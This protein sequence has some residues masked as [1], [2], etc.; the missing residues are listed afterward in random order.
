MRKS[1]LFVI[2]D[3]PFSASY[4][5]EVASC[6]SLQPI[7]EGSPDATQTCVP[8][9]EQYSLAP[10]GEEHIHA[11]KPFANDAAMSRT[12]LAETEKDIR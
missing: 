2:H 12:N 5:V 1:S 7:V 8:S 9:L 10:Y 4:V 11:L 6:Q 3:V